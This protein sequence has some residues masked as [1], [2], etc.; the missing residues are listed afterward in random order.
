[1]WV[2]AWTIRLRLCGLWG[3]GA[4]GR[5]AALLRPSPEFLAEV[6]ERCVWGLPKVWEAVVLWTLGFL[7]VA[8]VGVP[9]MQVLLGLDR[10]VPSVW[11]HTL[12]TLSVDAMEMAVAFG[13]VQACLRGDVGGATPAGSPPAAGW[14][15]P[16][17]LEGGRWVLPCLLV[18]LVTFPVVQRA[19]VFNQA[20]FPSAGW[21]WHPPDFS[22]LAEAGAQ[23]VF[24]FW[25]TL[26]S[27]IWEEVLFRGF[28]VSSLHRRFSS[29]PAVGISAVVFALLHF[30]PERLLPL[31]ILGFV[32]GFLYTKTNNLLACITVHCLWNVYAFFI[33][34]T[35]LVVVG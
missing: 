4:R 31:L 6:G 7:L 33:A 34:A 32:F 18:C 19:A 28:L 13:A 29:L 14:W 16:L 8:S 9:F 24:V 23:L 21:V 10:A 22:N 17:R 15:P 11:K 27:P 25:T 20:L 35:N 12:F 3:A 1:M 2:Q 5:A 26:V 30:S